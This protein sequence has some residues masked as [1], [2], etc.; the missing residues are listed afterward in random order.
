TV[1]RGGYGILYSPSVLQASG[2][3]G[4]SGTQGF[5]NTTSSSTSFDGGVTPNAFLKN[6]FPQGFNRPLGV[7]GGPETQIGLG[8]GDSYFNDYVNPIIQ[9]W[10][11]TLQ[12]DFGAGFIVEAGY[13]ANTGQHLIDGQSSMAYNQLPASY[14]ALGNQLLGSNQVANPF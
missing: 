7:A 8:I 1:F 11:A 12:R 9:E 4:S 10:S 6:P 5:T 2:T 14:F 3:S 13:L